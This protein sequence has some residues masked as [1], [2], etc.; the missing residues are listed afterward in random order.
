VTDLEYCVVHV[1]DVVVGSFVGCGAS[2]DWVQ[3]I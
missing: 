3:G 2:R 1:V